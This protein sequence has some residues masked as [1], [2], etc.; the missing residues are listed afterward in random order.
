MGYCSA[1]PHNAQWSAICCHVHFVV[2]SDINNGFMTTPAANNGNDDVTEL[3]VTS[4]WL[5]H[6]K[7]VLIWCDAPTFYECVIIYTSLYMW[8]DYKNSAYGCRW[9]LAHL[10]QLNSLSWDKMLQLKMV[11]M[12][13]S[14]QIPLLATFQ[15]YVQN[16][17]FCKTPPERQLFSVYIKYYST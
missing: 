13:H 8:C 17:H 3:P 16:W 5:W 11:C 10:I 14:C 6:H 2:V 9:Q 1:D 15:L 4:Q 7:Y 12:V